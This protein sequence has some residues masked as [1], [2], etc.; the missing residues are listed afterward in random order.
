MLFTFH[1]NYIFRVESHPTLA[2]TRYRFTLNKRS[3]ARAHTPRSR[4]FNTSCRSQITQGRGQQYI[5]HCGGSTLQQFTRRAH[6]CLCAYTPSMLFWNET[7]G[8]QFLTVFTHLLPKSLQTPRNAD[9]CWPAPILSDGQLCS[10]AL[11]PRVPHHFCGFCL[12]LKMRIA[13]RTSFVDLAAT[14][15]GATSQY[16]TPSCPTCPFEYLEQFVLPPPKHGYE[17]WGCGPSH[18]PLVTQIPIDGTPSS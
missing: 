7:R 9:S 17:R 16:N 2:E 14:I 8:T 15:N 4:R 5:Q 3:E 13:Q 18:R 11:V 12:S 6:P 10:A 1:D